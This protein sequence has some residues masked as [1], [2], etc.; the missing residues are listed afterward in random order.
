MLPWDDSKL[1]DHQLALREKVKAL[2][3]IRGEHPILGRGVR[4]T[5]SSTHDTW[6]Y[7]VSG[8]EGGE[9]LTVAINRADVVNTVSLAKP[10]YQDLVTGG[11]EVGGNVQ[12]PPRSFRILKAD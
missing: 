6:L 4:K 5:L 2:A 9:T 1:N 8:C 11:T 3:R 12:L 7:E 10:S